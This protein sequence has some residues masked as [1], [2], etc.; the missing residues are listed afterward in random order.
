MWGRRQRAQSDFS[1]E[2]QAH[3]ELEVD[4][5]RAEGLSEDDAYRQARRNLG[6]LGTAR[7][8]FYEFGRWLWLEHLAQDTRLAL[9]R[10]RNAPVFTAATVLTLALGIGATTSI[11]TLVH[12][13][14]LKSLP[15][16]KPNE[17]YRLGK[18]SRCCYYGG[19]SQD[20]EFSLVSYDLYKHFRDHTKGFAELAAFSA[21]ES[22]LGV[23]RAGRGETA[24]SYPAES[25]SGNYF[26][27]FGIKAY[28]GRMLTV[29]DDQ[30]DAAPVVVM[31]FRLWQG[32]YGSDPSVIGGVFNLNDKP[33]TVVG[34]TPPG[35]FGDTL[36]NPPPDFFLPLRPGEGDTKSP[37][38]HWLD[39]IGRIKPETTPASIQGEMRVE[40]KQWLRSHWNEMDAN[41]RAR[42]PEQ[43]LFLVPG[44]AG[45]TYLRETYEHWLQ[46]LM[47][48]TGFVLLIVCA[49]IA[50]LLLV[51]GLERR[52]QTALSMALGAQAPRLIR[53]ALTE[54]VLLSVLG[55]AAGSTI[56]YA[57]THLLLHFAFPQI[58]D[59][60][61]VPIS[62]SP[63]MPVLLFAA[64]VSLLTGIAF[65]VA[66][67]WMTTRIAPIEALRGANRS[68]TR[69]A[70]LPRK[71]LVILQAALSLALLSTSGLLT[72]ALHSLENQ[73]FGFDANR[74]TVVNFDPRLAGYRADQ[75]TP[76]YRRIHDSL[77]S[78]PGVSGVAL[79]IYSPLSGNNYD[80]NVWVDGRPAP[81]P[82]DD[83]DASWERVTE[84]YFDVI[85]NPILKGRGITEQDTTA[86]RHVAVVNEAFARKFFKNEN[87]I[88]KH[89]GRLEMGVS[90]QHEI[91]GIAK[92]ARYL[93]SDLD[94]PIGPFFFLPETQYDIYPYTAQTEGDKSSHFLRD[95][96]I[97]TKPGVSFPATEVRRAI[98]SINPNLPIIS[99]RTLKEQVAGQFSQQRLIAHLTSF[100]GV[101]SLVLASVGLYGVTA[102]NVG[103]RTNEIG[104]RM[105][106]GANRGQVIG[107]V[108]RGAF[109]LVVLGLLLG[110]PFTLA[111]G[112]FL[113]HQ[114]YGISPYNFKV[115]V[116]ALV[117]LGFS[118]LVAAFI[119]ALR[120]SSISPLQA[121]RV[122]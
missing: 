62:A 32:K 19:Y 117:A 36:R 66:P 90:R 37:N 74:R 28:A 59:S 22:L 11:F 60:A 6:N 20:K 68:T 12:A 119:P 98:A 87:P 70:S 109:A 24:Q 120:A 54:S 106:L 115:M 108:L 88:G 55:G 116:I 26:N 10:L 76:L 110:V 114:L 79:C 99:I 105:A 50:N 47:T 107:L 49:N 45:I 69:T 122:E 9:R 71:A 15:V 85:G 14:L 82:K 4:R 101:L 2:L 3:L 89:F 33:F 73:D 67:A 83:V 17:L 40:L 46:I 75:L 112:R 53:Q 31:S 39:L 91:V 43:T 30:A 100:F 1:E 96:V 42:F 51:R 104:V 72:A 65:G 13:V 77:S 61:G 18:E 34:I 5:L 41:D 48:V 27:M 23:Q 25:V 103:R 52:Q 63:S 7:E 64:C 113:G 102:Y 93:S 81:G 57:G 78:I 16:A 94:K 38:L 8:R 118:A 92:D 35:F 80:A 97:V 44:G 111:M 29:A 121:L 58:G 21:S 84:G 56:A 86:S 95:I